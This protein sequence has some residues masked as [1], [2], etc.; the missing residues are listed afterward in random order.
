MAQRQGSFLLVRSLRADVCQ[1]CGEIYLDADAS[2]QIDTAFAHKEKAEQHPDV[3][4]FICK[5]G[6]QFREAMPSSPCKGRSPG[7]L[8]HV[9]T[10]K[11]L[12]ILGVIC[13]SCRAAKKRK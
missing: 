10:R 5:A 4:V 9:E 12:D 7:Q 2:R 1:Q 13:Y 11:I 6:A 8:E 3:P